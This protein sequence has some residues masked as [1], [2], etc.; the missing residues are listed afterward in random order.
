MAATVA[1]VRAIAPEFA[2]VSDSDVQAFLDD[3]ALQ[4]NASI[5]GAKRDLA[6][7]YLAAHLLGTAR[8]DLAMAAGPVQSE[9][10]GQVSRS[11]AVQT[12][13]QP[14]SQFDATRH[15]REY[16]RM[17]LQLGAGLQVC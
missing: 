4:L 10:V 7:K 8:P 2:T 12:S 11:Y 14:G 5:W 13:A 17:V 6:H 1:Q 16:R 15:G 9:S 3:A